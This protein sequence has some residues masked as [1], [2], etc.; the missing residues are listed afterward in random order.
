M[1][2]DNASA[3]KH[4]NTPANDLSKR[5]IL[6][7]NPLI[8]SILFIWDP[9]RRPSPPGSKNNPVSVLLEVLSTKIDRTGPAVHGDDC[10]DGIVIQRLIRRGTRILRENDI[11]D[12]V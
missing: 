2:E 6:V 11:L 1:Q 3:R 9:G 12:D 7:F 5:H 4:V 8:K 10:T